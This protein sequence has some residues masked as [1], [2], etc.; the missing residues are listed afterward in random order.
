MKQPD[1]V[2]EVSNRPKPRVPRVPLGLALILARH[3][4]IKPFAVDPHRYAPLSGV[5]GALG[6]IIVVGGVAAH[7]LMALH[8]RVGHARRAICVRQAINHMANHRL[9]LPSVE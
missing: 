5:T 1:A 2:E 6:D 9:C 3:F 4:V 8:L 7:E